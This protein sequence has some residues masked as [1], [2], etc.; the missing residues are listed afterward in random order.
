MFPEKT[1][2]VTIAFCC[3]PLPLVS[4]FLVS[5]KLRPGE[6]VRTMCTRMHIKRIPFLL[7]IRSRY[8]HCLH[9]KL[10]FLPNGISKTQCLHPDYCSRQSC[11]VCGHTLRGRDIPETNRKCIKISKAN[12]HGTKPQQ[13]RAKPCTIL[14]PKIKQ[15]KGK[16]KERKGNTMRDMP[17]YEGLNK[18]NEAARRT[19]AGRI[20]NRYHFCTDVA[21]RKRERDRSKGQE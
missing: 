11:N 21:T 5:S 13:K 6:K 12:I 8:V 20:R 3:H 9:G 19:R 2:T 4:C 10:C 16:G 14:L 18:I 15:T 7:S 1:K 17:P